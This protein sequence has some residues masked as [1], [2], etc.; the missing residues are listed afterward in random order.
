MNDFEVTSKRQTGWWGNVSSATRTMGFESWCVSFLWP[1]SKWTQVSGST[2]RH[3]LAQLQ[4]GRSPGRVNC[5]LCSGSHRLNRG[6]SGC[7]PFWALASLPNWQ[8][9]S[10]GGWWLSSISLRAVGQGP[11]QL[12][13]HLSDSY[14]V[15]PSTGFQTGLLGS[16]RPE[17]EP[18]ALILHLQEKP[19]PSH[20]GLP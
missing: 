8:N 10:P 11:S 19:G 14:H 13:R 4:W 6:A 15:T 7:V 9:S 20:R 1:Q 12:L 17:K 16:L 2:N 5:V 18:L 3:L